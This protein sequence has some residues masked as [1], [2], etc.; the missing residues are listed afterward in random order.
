MEREF[1]KCG[2]HDIK[3]AVIGDV[4]LDR[5]L[6]GTVSRIS[7][8]APVPIVNIK[9]TREVLGG[10]ANVAANLAG[11]GCQVFMG[12]VIGN[13][14]N[15][16]LL[17]KLMEQQNIDYSGL[18]ASLDR[19]TITKVRVLGGQQ[20]MLRMDFEEVG[21]L[22]SDETDKLKEWLKTLL[23]NGINGISISDYAKGVCSSEFCQWV[24][25]KAHEY[26]IPVLVDPKGKNWNKYQGASFIT[27]NI[28][29]LSEIVGYSCPNENDAVV[30]AAISIKRK[31][32]IENV[33]ATRSEQGITV[34]S[35]QK[36]YHDPAAEKE[37][38][39]VSGA[40][41]TVAATLLAMI[42]GGIELEKAIKLANKAAGIVVN[43]VG[44]YP[45]KNSE[46][47]MEI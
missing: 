13:D 20:Q 17:E 46:L 1:L 21:D 8:E 4:M 30:D 16:V 26:G 42:A 43:K 35:S 11:L 34:V 23:D 47:M 15:K 2:I 24:I 40:G 36:V 29:E 27:P 33:V 37:V 5:Y 25:K 12:G 38:F 14:S 32:N 9:K 44:T 10:A 7:P 19:S 39:D 18:V 41:D 28:K 6:H 31:Y 22:T 45:V 3:I